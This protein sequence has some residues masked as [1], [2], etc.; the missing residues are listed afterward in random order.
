MDAPLTRSDGHHSDASNNNNS[1][2]VHNTNGTWDWTKVLPDTE[3]IRLFKS[4][5]WSST[6]LGSLQSWDSTLRS[7]TFQV[8]ADTRPACLYWYD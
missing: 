5:D 7:A 2:T 8:L 1:S 4:V 3:H 6:R